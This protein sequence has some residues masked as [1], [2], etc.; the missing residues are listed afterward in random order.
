MSYVRLTVL[1]YFLYNFNAIIQILS[2][3]LL[4]FQNNSE[5]EPLI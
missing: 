5:V 2:F 4:P 3:F 1:N